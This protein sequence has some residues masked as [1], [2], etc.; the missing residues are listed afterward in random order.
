MLSKG[1][2]I[3]EFRKITAGLPDHV[4]LGAI[5]EGQPRLEIDRYRIVQNKESKKLGVIVGGKDLSDLDMSDSFHDT[6][7]VLS[8]DRFYDPEWE[9]PAARRAVTIADLFKK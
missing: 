1:M 8:A 3:G 9:D 2:T 7:K 5:V 6:Y 4:S